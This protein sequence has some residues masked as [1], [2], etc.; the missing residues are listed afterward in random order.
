MQRVKA[1]Q[2]RHRVLA[3]MHEITQKVEQQ[4]TCH[5]TQ[6]RIGDRPGRETHP[7][8]RFQLMAEPHWWFEYKS[9]ENQIEDPEPDIPQPPPQG[10]ELPP[11][12]R[13]AEFPKRDDEQAAQQDDEGQERLLARSS[14]A[15][16]RARLVP[17]G[18]A[19][20]QSGV[21]HTLEDDAPSGAER[22]VSPLVT[23]A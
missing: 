16:C 19:R 8:H 23:I 7:C 5:K 1:P 17:G 13:P 10:G 12:P 3:A 14:T 11:P 22:S 15:S 18:R 9:G 2:K 4:K 21:G 6:R 20:F